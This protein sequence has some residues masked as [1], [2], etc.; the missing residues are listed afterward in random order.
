MASTSYSSTH[1]LSRTEAKAVSTTPWYIW[2]SVLAATSATIG[3]HWDISWHRSIGRDSFWTPAHMA[4]YMC[5]VLAGISCGYLI[6][7]TTLSRASSLANASVKIF[8]F[9]GPLGAFIAAWGGIAMLTSA[10]FDN[11]W[12]DAYGLDVKIVS[13]PHVLLIAG[14]FAVKMGVL[15]LVLSNM[16]RASERVQKQYDL[17]FLYVGA[18]IVTVLEILLMDYLN[19]PLLHSSWPYRMTAIFI[20]VVLAGI[21]R[22]SGQKYAATIVTGI[23]SLFIIGLILVLPLFPAEPKLGPVFQK[24]TQFIPPGFPPLIIVPAL[25]LDLLWQRTRSWNPWL[26]AL[27]SGV[28]FVGIFL[29]AEWPFASFLNSPASANRFFGTGYMDYGTSPNSYTARHLFYMPES[30]AQFSLWI[31]ISALFAT[32]STRL[33]FAWGEWMKKIQR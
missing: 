12:H 6:L 25:C 16:N 4:I 26:L 11:W 3:G 28:L 24:V 1:A 30:A 27:L 18:L 5:G 17:L 29:A 33:G 2:C 22:A 15:V 7:S 19:R 14:I 9:R 23:Y 13:P 21:W 31:G 8:G 20:P 10:P 32:A